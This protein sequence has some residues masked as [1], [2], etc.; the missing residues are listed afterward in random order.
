MFGFRR[1]CRCG[2]LYRS[3]RVEYVRLFGREVEKS[4]YWCA[5]CLI[6]YCA[7][8]LQEIRCKVNSY[9]SRL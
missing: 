3:S 5:C 4:G 1:C 2:K 8:S 7:E 6:E 9:A